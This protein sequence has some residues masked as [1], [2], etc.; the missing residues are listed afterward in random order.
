[1]EKISDF[2]NILR[3]ITCTL[4]MYNKKTKIF[5]CNIIKLCCYKLTLLQWLFEKIQNDPNKGIYLGL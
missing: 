3:P 4:D 1:M 5:Y 2:S